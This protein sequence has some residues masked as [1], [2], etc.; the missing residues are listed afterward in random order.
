MDNIIRGANWYC[1]TINMRLRAEITKLPVLRRDM[2]PNVLG[3]G[4]FALDLPAEI[5]ALTADMSV[6]STPPE[7]RARFGREPGD[8]TEIAYYESLLNV[9]PGNANGATQP[10]SGSGPQL[11][12]RVVM[13]KGL[14]NE[15]EQPGVKGMRPDAAARLRWSSIV[16]YHDV[17][18]G[19]TV[20]KFDIRNNELIIEGVNYTAEHNRLVAA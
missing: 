18:D 16:L 15:V 9:F 19:V 10:T 8:W 17:V 3:G 5:A 1:G 20:H 4:V 7:V 2:L 12:G 14:L 13:L 6:N 11:K